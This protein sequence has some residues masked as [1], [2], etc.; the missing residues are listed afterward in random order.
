[1]LALKKYKKKFLQ[2]NN[3][4]RTVCERQ[5]VWQ[6]CKVFVDKSVKI[7]V[8]VTETNGLFKKALQKT[9]IKCQTDVA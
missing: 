4:E 8:V 7:P 2:D 9:I 6:R 3:L 5:K 1:M